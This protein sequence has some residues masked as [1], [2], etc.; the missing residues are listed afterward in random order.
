MTREFIVNTFLVQENCAKAGLEIM[1]KLTTCVLI[2][3]TFDACHFRT[4]ALL[5]A[6]LFLHFRFVVFWRKNIGA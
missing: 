5:A 2:S 6:F 1:V 3:P 4:K